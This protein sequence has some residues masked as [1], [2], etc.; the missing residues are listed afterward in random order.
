MIRTILTVAALAI[1]AAAH[2]EPQC[3]S[4]RDSDN[5]LAEGMAQPVFA[6]IADDLGSMIIVYQFPDTSYAIVVENEGA[7]MACLMHAGPNSVA[8]PARANM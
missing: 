8:L 5:F 3:I 4:M 2:A 1:P 7:G 6:G